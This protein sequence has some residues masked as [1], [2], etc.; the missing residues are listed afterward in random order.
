MHGSGDAPHASLAELRPDRSFSHRRNL[1]RPEVHAS[2]DPV[3]QLG[4]AAAITFG[5]EHDASQ[6]LIMLSFLEDTHAG[7]QKEDPACVSNI[8]FE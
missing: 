3:I 7:R 2:T 5:S 4:K 8:S 1:P 6:I